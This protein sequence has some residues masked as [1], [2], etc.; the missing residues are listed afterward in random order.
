MEIT[1]SEDMFTTKNPQ[2]FLPGPDEPAFSRLS[3]HKLR[4]RWFYFPQDPLSCSKERPG[5][6]QEKKSLMETLY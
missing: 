3:E 6:G 4:D 5:A 2:T 1:H